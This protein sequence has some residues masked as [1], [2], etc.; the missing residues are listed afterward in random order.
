MYRFVYNTLGGVECRQVQLIWT[1]GLCRVLVLLQGQCRAG[2]RRGSPSSLP[3]PCRL[4]SFQAGPGLPQPSGPEL[5]S[6]RRPL[7][8]AG[9]RRLQNSWRPVPNHSASASA[10][11][12]SSTS[13]ALLGTGL[14]GAGLKGRLALAQGGREPRR[15]RPSVQEQQREAEPPAPALP[16]PGMADAGASGL[17]ELCRRGQELAA[18]VLPLLSAPRQSCGVG[19]SLAAPGPRGDCPEQQG[20]APVSLPA[21]PGQ[22]A[23]QPGF[24]QLLAVMP[25]PF[26]R[27]APPER[28]LLVPVSAAA[29]P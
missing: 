14:R 26:T 28:A 10:G 25:C 17:P 15:S 3:A 29:R 16:S 22:P 6:H 8:W 21:A 18:L 9:A 11:A 13:P 27:P 5:C 12:S 19:R 23:L 4:L 7:S 20:H 24:S 1:D 2:L